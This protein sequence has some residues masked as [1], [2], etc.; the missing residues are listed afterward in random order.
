[1]WMVFEHLTLPAALELT[2]PSFGQHSVG[3]IPFGGGSFT[4]GMLSR[5]CSTIACKLLDLTLGHVNSEN[6]PLY[7]CCVK[8]VLG[9]WLF[10]ECTPLLAHEKPQF[11]RRYHRLGTMT[12]FCNPSTQKVKSGRSHS[13]LHSKCSTIHLCDRMS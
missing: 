3:G 1:M 6:I 11:H 9:V 4:M 13:W 8:S 7:V 5:L 10:V 12:N 2:A